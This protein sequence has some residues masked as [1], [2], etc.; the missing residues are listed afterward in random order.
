MLEEPPLEGGCS[1]GQVRYRLTARPLIVHCCHCSRCQRETGSAFAVNV[2]IEPAALDH[3][4]GALSRVALPTASGNPQVASRCASCGTT[5]WSEY[6]RRAPLRALRAGTL[7]EPA[8]APPDIHIYTR[9]KLPWV[10]L[11]P[12]IPAVEEY[13]RRSELW[14]EASLERYRRAL[15]AD[16]E[17]RNP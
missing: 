3:L 11:Q 12:G 4:T 8:R 5:V 13:Y 15:P 7:D 6:G 17:R 10:V 2:I 16:T 9:T 14:S 1:C